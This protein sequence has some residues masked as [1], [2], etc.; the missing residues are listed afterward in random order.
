MAYKTTVYADME[1]SLVGNL[2]R[3]RINYF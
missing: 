2:S 1:D 3:S